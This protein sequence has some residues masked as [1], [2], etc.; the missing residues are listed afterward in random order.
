MLESLSKQIG[1]DT[2]LALYT[3]LASRMVYFFSTLSWLF[4]E[5]TS[6]DDDTIFLKVI[7]DTNKEVLSQFD[8]RVIKAGSVD[9]LIGM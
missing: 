4:S 2:F 1:F 9:I 5:A 8:D 7:F 3:S 6:F